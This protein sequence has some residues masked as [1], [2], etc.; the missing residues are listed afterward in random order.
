MDWNLAVMMAEMIYWA[1]MRA[2]WMDSSL[3]EMT[4]EMMLTGFV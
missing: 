1:V 3:A 4:A 2:V